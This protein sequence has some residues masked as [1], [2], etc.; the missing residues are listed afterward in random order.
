M[1]KIEI[2]VRIACDRKCFYDALKAADISEDVVIVQDRDAFNLHIELP[3]AGGLAA[4]PGFGE[5]KPHL[6]FARCDGE[7]PRHFAAA[8]SVEPLGLKDRHWRARRYRSMAEIDRGG[9]GGRYG[10]A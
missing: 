1:Q 6:I 3:D 4:G 8:G 5:V 2:Q 9:R 7:I 10:I